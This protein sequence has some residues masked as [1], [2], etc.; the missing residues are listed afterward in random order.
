MTAAPVPPAE[1][2]YV[3]TYPELDGLRALAAIAVVATHTAFWAGTYGQGLL[4]AAAQRLEIG[5]AIFFVLSGFLLGRPHVE[6]AV[7]GSGIEPVG[8]YYLKRALRILP[9]YW[10]TVVVALVALPDNRGADLTVWARNLLLVDHFVASGMPAGLTQM[11]SLSV[12]A[13]FYLALPFLGLLLVAVGRRSRRPVTAL[14]W[15]LA[16]LSAVGI[17]WVLA[18]RLVDHQAAEWATRHLPAHLTWFLA[19]LALAVLVADRG[20][21]GPTCRVTRLAVVVAR[22]R[23]TC[24]VLAGALYAVASTPLGGSPFL[25]APTASEAM[26]KHLLYGLCALLVVAPSVLAPRDDSVLAHRVARHLGHVSYSLFCCHL[27]VLEAVMRI[28]GFELFLVSW[29]LLFVLVLGASLVVAEVLYRCVER[30]AMR[31]VAVRRS[32]STAPPT[33]T[34]STPTT[35]H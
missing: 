5:V 2:G 4:G 22:D 35:N 1:R 28:G 27:I 17:G 16:V 8:R 23:T 21:A 9:V 13:S 20:S 34:A 6:R 15:S 14:L 11:W 25:V 29:P 24:W 12:E 7:H 19:G 31:L 26:V 33:T 30:P 3:R 18:S 10:L 32:G